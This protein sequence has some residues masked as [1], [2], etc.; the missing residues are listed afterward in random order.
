MHLRGR[1]VNKYCTDKDKGGNKTAKSSSCGVKSTCSLTSTASKFQRLKPF[2][3]F[4]RWLVICWSLKVCVNEMT[5][6]QRPQYKVGV[7]SKSKKFTG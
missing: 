1:V 7:F 2:Q 6:L 4:T 5:L 3:T